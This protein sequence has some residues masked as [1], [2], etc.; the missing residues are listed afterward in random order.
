MFGYSSSVRVLKGAHER[1]ADSDLDKDETVKA[2]RYARQ[3][4]ELMEEEEHYAVS[5]IKGAKKGPTD[6]RGAPYAV[7]VP[8]ELGA[9]VAQKLEGDVELV[10]NLA[11]RLVNVL[12]Q[13]NTT[14]PLRQSF[15]HA[16]QP[17][18]SARDSIDRGSLKKQTESDFK[19][20]R[21]QTSALN[22]YCEGLFEP[23]AI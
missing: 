23:M 5:S 1:A 22:Q 7:T 12:K 21:D 17:A 15:K 4:V 9:I 20:K 3:V 6:W 16:E 10:K 13:D 18:V 14:A 19:N 11:N 2:L 8:T